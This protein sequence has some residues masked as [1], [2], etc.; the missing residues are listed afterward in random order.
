M[1]SKTTETKAPSSEIPVSKV[2][3]F[4]SYLLETFHG[5]PKDPQTVELVK[6]NSV[7]PLGD[8][9]FITRSDTHVILVYILSKIS[10]EIIDTAHQHRCLSI[11]PE[12]S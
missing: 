2:K 5:T 1:S 6:G 3:D 12:L 10:K 7:K 4:T 11:T 8:G 9:K